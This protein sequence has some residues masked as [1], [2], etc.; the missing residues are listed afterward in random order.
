MRII[1]LVFLAIMSLSIKASEKIVYYCESRHGRWMGYALG[2]PTGL[3]EPLG[4]PRE[5]CLLEAPDDGRA[6][7]GAQAQDWVLS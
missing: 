7:P 6:S 5:L 4:A 1:L 3:W 2:A